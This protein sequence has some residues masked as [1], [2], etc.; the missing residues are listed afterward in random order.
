MSTEPLVAGPA[1]SA[2]I[3]AESL[4]DS[5]Y[6]CVVSVEGEEVRTEFLRDGRPWNAPPTVLAGGIAQIDFT[7][8]TQGYCFLNLDPSSRNHIVGP[9]AFD[10]DDESPKSQLHAGFVFP[11]VLW[12]EIAEDRR[13][14]RMTLTNRYHHRE[15][16]RYALHVSVVSCSGGRPLTSPDP[17]L[18][19]D[20]YDTPVGGDEWPPR[21]S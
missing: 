13:S 4:V 5:I 11:P 21:K 3:P 7:L 15:A 18:I 20:P 10:F 17:T 12:V 14:A 1:V 8:T 19:E 9:F 2:C 6:S 16:H